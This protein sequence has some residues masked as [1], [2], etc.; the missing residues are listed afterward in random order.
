M[1]RTKDTQWIAI[2]SANIP[3]AE[4]FETK[5]EAIRHAEQAA[6]KT[7]R[8]CPALAIDEAQRAVHFRGRVCL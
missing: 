4:V 8:N 6:E 2:D 7:P 5:A 1:K 3:N